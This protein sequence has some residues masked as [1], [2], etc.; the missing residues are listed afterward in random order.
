M[1]QRLVVKQVG[2]AI[3]GEVRIDPNG[4]LDVRAGTPALKSIV[5]CLIA[6]GTVRLSTIET[7]SGVDL[8]R[9]TPVRPDSEGFLE[10]LAD[11][12]TK[13]AEPYEGRRLRA[14]VEPTRGETE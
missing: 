3:V 11:A 9:A 2:G 1:D 12:I 8:T 6:A 14:W 7:N 4:E 5:R 10:G 13:S